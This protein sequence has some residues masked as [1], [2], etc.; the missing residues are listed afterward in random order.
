MV[1]GVKDR[2]PDPIISTELIFWARPPQQ[3]G[4]PHG[5]VDLY[6]D[7]V[8]TRR[9]AIQ[10]PGGVDGFAEK[11]GS[12]ESL[13]SDFRNWRRKLIEHIIALGGD[14]A[15]RMLWEKF[16]EPA[17]T[18][19]TGTSR[20]TNVIQPDDIVIPEE[21]YI[22]KHGDPDYNGK[23]HRR[24]SIPGCPRGVAMPGPRVWRI[25]RDQLSEVGLRTDL[26]RSDDNQQL[27]DDML[28]VNFDALGDSV[29]GSRATGEVVSLAGVFGLQSRALTDQVRASSPPAILPIQGP[30]A[31]SSF[32]AGIRYPGPEN[33]PP[34]PPGLESPSQSQG[35]AKDKA[36]GKAKAKS[37]G[38]AGGSRL[39]ADVVPIKPSP[40]GDGA[41]PSAA[42]A[43][44]RGAPLRDLVALTAAKAAVWTQVDE[45]S[46]YWSDSKAQLR[47]TL[48]FAN[49]LKERLDKMQEGTEEFMQHKIAYKK[50][51]AIYMIT[52]AFFKFGGFSSGLVKALDEAEHYLQLPPFAAQLQHPSFLLQQRHEVHCLA[53]APKDYWGFLT[54]EALVAAGHKNED[55]HIMRVQKGLLKQVIETIGCSSADFPTA[56]ASYHRLFDPHLRKLFVAAPEVFAEVQ[57]CQDLSYFSDASTQDD[58]QTLLSIVAATKDSDKRVVSAFASIANGLAVI[59][60]ARERALA[61]EAAGHHQ[62]DIVDA[63]KALEALYF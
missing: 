18:L 21:E 59:E 57:Q 58:A 61:I 34:P 5:Y 15:A 46:E 35:K 22:K 39:P 12:S 55:E 62:Q 13:L 54:R 40:P 3:S 23:G 42:A 20:R 28:R 43:K 2:E 31:F 36:K 38:K 49:D 7:R 45:A 24:I 51:H 48:R 41:L 11:L 1:E 8:Y 30:D 9:Y 17:T 6:C 29:F 47:N 37:T 14:R 60:A 19:Y 63:A 26:M 33:P 32:A 10:Y 44:G 50:A 25:R 4:T 27:G 56:L 52:S 53:A 16:S